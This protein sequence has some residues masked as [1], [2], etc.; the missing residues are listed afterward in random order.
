M[1]SFLEE[2][3]HREVKGEAGLERQQERPLAALAEDQSLVVSAHIK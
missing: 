2:N 1:S 3:I